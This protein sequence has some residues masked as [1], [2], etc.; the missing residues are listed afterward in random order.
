MT[1]RETEKTYYAERGYFSGL[2]QN[3]SPQAVAEYE[4][5]VKILLERYNTTIYE[6]RFIVGGAVEVFTLF[7]LRSAGIPA[8]GYGDETAAGDIILPSKRLLSIKCSFTGAKDDIRL[9]NTMGQ[10]RSFWQ[11][12]TLFILSGV[13]IVYGD[14]AMAEDTDLKRSKDALMLRRKAVERFAENDKNLF[15]VNIAQKASKV[16]TRFSHKASTAV[17]KQILYEQ[18][19]ETL[20]KEVSD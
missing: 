6:N 8:Q 2:K 20:L 9:I 19:L 14:P 3:A 13:G 10:A 5:A 11:T 1:V 15:P 16:M 17:A 4:Q 12:A 18:K 7:L